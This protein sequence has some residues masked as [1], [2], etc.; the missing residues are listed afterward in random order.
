MS[1]GSCLA[2]WG[3]P[4]VARGRPD[5]SWGG[6]GGLWEQLRKRLGSFLEPWKP[7]GRLQEG[8]S[9]GLPFF[10]RLEAILNAKAPP[11]CAKMPPKRRPKGC[12]T[13]LKRRLEQQIAEVAESL[14]FIFQWKS[15]IFAVP[16]VLLEVQIV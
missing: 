12:Q 6:L 16:R 2:S 14:I 3:S 10:A 13:E 1:W 8:V 15:L 5:G 4:G 9:Q 11:K 7:L